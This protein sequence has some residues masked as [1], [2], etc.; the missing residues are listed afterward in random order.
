MFFRNVSWLSLEYTALYNRRYNSQE[1]AII[2]ILLLWRICSSPRLPCA[3]LC[4]EHATPYDVM[5]YGACAQVTSDNGGRPVTTASV[6][7]PLPGDD[8]VLRGA[9][10]REVSQAVFSSGSARRAWRLLYIV[11][12]T[13]WK[14]DPFSRQRGCPISTNPQLSDRNKNLVIS[15]DGGLIPRQTGRLTVGRNIR[16][17]DGQRESHQVVQI[18]FNPVPGGIT[19]PPCSWGI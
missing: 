4:S 14:T 2:T 1:T 16:L 5:L 12:C 8:E 17:T 6:Y 7:S 11:H 15:P 9:I 19:G 10:I 13:L 3:T 18:E